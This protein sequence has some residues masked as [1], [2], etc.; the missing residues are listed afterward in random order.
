MQ[1]FYFFRQGMLILNQLALLAYLS[2]MALSGQKPGEQA[3]LAAGLC[4]LLFF[5]GLYTVCRDVQGSRLLGDFACLQLLLAWQCLLQVFSGHALSGQAAKL[6]MPLCLW[7]SL[8]FAQSFLFQAAAYRGQRAFLGMA[9]LCAA[10]ACL[11]FFRS[12]RAFA[13]AYQ[14]QWLL[15][16]LGLLG[17]LLL[18]R[19]RVRFVLAGQWRELLISCLLTLPLMAAYILAFWGRPEYLAGVGAYLL[20][21]PA[22]LGIHAILL[23]AP[24]G[25]AESSREALILLL[26][27]MIAG[28]LWLALL[29][30][31]P[32]LFLLA[33]AQ[34]GALLALVH[35]LLCCLR[36]GAHPGE[37]EGRH[38]YAAALERIRWE[39]A[40][41]RE[42]SDY[43]HDAILQDIL[44]M[45]NLLAKAEQP[46]VRQ[47]LA[48]TLDG[49]SR[50]IRRRMQQMHP[51]LARGLTLRENIQ[52]LL[53]AETAGT[54]FSA[55]LDCSAALFLPEPY[56]LIIFRMLRELVANA[57]RHSGGDALTVSLAL[58]RQGVSLSVSD[59][60]RGFVP[61][62]ALDGKGGGRGLCSIREQAEL[63]GGSLQIS[64]APGG[65]AR[66]SVFIPIKGEDSYAYSARR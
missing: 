62:A 21:L 10:A 52:A 48:D 60:G 27:L 65:G 14:L 2:A 19:E 47:L 4:S 23:R 55:R 44:S 50:S 31:V 39:E 5:D 57:C 32:P 54:P 17:I 28:A 25:A 63:L 18:H 36:L 59:N 45:K 6:L 26:A 43:L 33:F 46:P 9:G 38:F 34:L 37:G 1:R 20:W 51:I 30:R 13:A 41:R 29:L 64:P 56:D 66:V 53:E 35:H 40:L 61:P 8:R 7:G 42:F 11:C 3:L 24:K 16:A 12:P 58:N 22:L 15:G 49:L